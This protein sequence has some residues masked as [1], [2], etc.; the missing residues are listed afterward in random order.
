M[1]F[2][3]HPGNPCPGQ[4]HDLEF[5]IVHH[6]EGQFDAQLIA[7]DIKEVIVDGVAHIVLSDVVGP[8]VDDMMGL[9]DVD[10]R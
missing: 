8:G 7:K 3:F 2:R 9:D 6:L 4:V 5:E 10:D 1:S